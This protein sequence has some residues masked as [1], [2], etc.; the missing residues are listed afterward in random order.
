[1]THAVDMA[2]VIKAETNSQ[3]V[4]LAV[5][6]SCTSTIMNG[7]YDYYIVL[8]NR[9]WEALAAYKRQRSGHVKTLITQRK[10]FQLSQPDLSQASVSPFVLSHAISRYCLHSN[11]QPV[12]NNILAV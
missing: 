5:F 3:E 1:M 9:H 8:Y 4:S 11:L 12:Y 6:Q 10:R 7:M 2:R